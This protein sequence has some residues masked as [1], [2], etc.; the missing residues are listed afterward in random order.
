MSAIGS[1]GG[2]HPDNCRLVRKL[3]GGTALA[4]LSPQSFRAESVSSPRSA[5]WSARRPGRFHGEILGHAAFSKDA[6]LASTR[7]RNGGRRGE[8]YDLGRTSAERGDDA[9]LFRTWITG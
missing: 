7:R 1:E 6:L 9:M 5:I 3:A 2:P 8:L 4:R